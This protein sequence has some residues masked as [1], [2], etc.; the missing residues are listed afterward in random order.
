VGELCPKGKGEKKVGTTAFGEKG[1][2][3]ELHIPGG[4]KGEGKRGLGGTKIIANRK[5]KGRKSAMSRPG[6]KKRGVIHAQREK[7]PITLETKERKGE[8]KRGQLVQEKKKNRT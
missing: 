7:M 2:N 5:S 8:G 4:E 6:G 1:K 3:A